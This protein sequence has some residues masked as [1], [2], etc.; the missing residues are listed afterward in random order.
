VRVDELRA[1]QHEVLAALARPL[2]G[3]SRARA[4]LPA[5]AADDPAIAALAAALIAPSATLDPAARLEIYRRQCW[6][7]LLGA[8]ADD[9]PALRW[10]LGPTAFAALA[11]R[12]LIAHPPARAAGL[13]ELGAGLPA[14]IATTTPA[15]LHAHELARLE[16]AWSRAFTAGDGAPVAAADLAQAPLALAPHLTILACRTAPDRLWQRARARGPRAR[17][18]V[19]AASPRVHVAVFRDHLA[20]DVVRLHPAAHAILAGLTAGAGLGE[21]LE[22]AAP[23]LPARG[24]AARVR[25]WF[26]DWT[27]RGW[28]VSAAAERGAEHLAE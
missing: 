16:A 14:F 15:A 7:R 2:T 5:G 23:L 11:E 9:F 1:R 21:A 12:Y 20:R 28:L 13:A 6:L 8:L 3:A 18:G 10:L 25:A 22:R 26:R 19:V 4:A 24:A 27:A 17:L